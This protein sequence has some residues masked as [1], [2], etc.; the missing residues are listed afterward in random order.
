[1][2]SLQAGPL[3]LASGGAGLE[4]H[5]EGGVEQEQQTLGCTA[6]PLRAPIQVRWL[7]LL[8]THIC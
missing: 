1:M 7:L 5:L 3:L 4:V 8:T 2:L 6:Q